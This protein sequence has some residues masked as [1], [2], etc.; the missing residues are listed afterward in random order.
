MSRKVQSYSSKFC[1]MSQQQLESFS[2]LA[3]YIPVQISSHTRQIW[4]PLLRF[5]TKN[6]SWGRVKAR[7]ISAKLLVGASGVPSGVGRIRSL[8]Y[9]WI[10]AR[11]ARLVTELTASAHNTCSEIKLPHN[12]SGMF[13]DP[14]H[15]VAADAVGHVG[16]EERNG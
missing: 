14:I 16:V 7:R 2:R 1:H 15:Y 9:G 5:W 10:Q 4:G 6:H 11:N 13:D 8:G 12:L 3:K